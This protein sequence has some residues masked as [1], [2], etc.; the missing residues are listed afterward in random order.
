MINA[1]DDIQPRIAYQVTGDESI[2][3]YSGPSGYSTA[4]VEVDCIADTAKGC[5]TL[6]A[7]VKRVLDGYSGSIGGVY[8]VPSV[9]KDGSDIEQALIE[10]TEQ[11]V[12][13]RTLSFEMLYR[14]TS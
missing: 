8:I 6:S 13:L 4:T 5:A 10:G 7:N 9:L 12:Y 3:T 2:D 1:Q 14:L 11:V